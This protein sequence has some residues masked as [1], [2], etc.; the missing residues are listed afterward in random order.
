MIVIAID[1][2]AENFNL[3]YWFWEKLKDH[4]VRQEYQKQFQS[5][6]ALMMDESPPPPREL[7]LVSWIVVGLWPC[8]IVFGLL[9]QWCATGRGRHHEDD[10]RRGAQSSRRNG[11]L[12]LNRIRRDEI[13]EEQRQKKYRYLYQ[14]RTAHGDIISQVSKSWKH[15]R[16]FV[17]SN[18]TAIELL[19][20]VCLKAKRSKPII[21]FY[22]FSLLSHL[23]RTPA[24]D[25]FMMT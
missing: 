9:C 13:R 11:Q 3:L 10:F 4:S 24:T 12:D 19:C 5:T 7:C 17:E 22:Y 2:F 14:V 16:T 20:I 6:L 8:L 1:Y 21:I 25:F 18:T 15:G 23:V